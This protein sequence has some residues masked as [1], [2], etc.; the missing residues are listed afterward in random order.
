MKKLVSLALA[1]LMLGMHFWYMPCRGACRKEEITV[2][3][4]DYSTCDYYKTQIAAFE[5]A[6]PQYTVRVIESPSADYGDKIQIMLSAAIR[7]T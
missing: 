3:L 2:S 5:E 7:W 1:V 4:W 6:Y